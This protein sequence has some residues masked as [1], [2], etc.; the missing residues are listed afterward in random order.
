MSVT[1]RSTAVFCCLPIAESA[2]ERS[3]RSPMVI[4]PVRPPFTVVVAVDFELEV[5]A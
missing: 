3:V 2:P 1:A 5:T 4:V